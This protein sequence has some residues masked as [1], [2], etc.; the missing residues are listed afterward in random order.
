MC[1]RENS[2]PINFI[3]ISLSYHNISNILFSCYSS[4]L[5]FSSY[6]SAYNR[7]TH[8]RIFSSSQLLRSFS[9]NVLVHGV[10]LLWWS[11]HIFSTLQNYY[12]TMGDRDNF[13]DLVLLSR[14]KRK[15]KYLLLGLYL[16]IFYFCLP[17]LLISNV[18]CFDDF[19]S[20]H[21][22]CSCPDSLSCWKCFL[23]FFA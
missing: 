23:L 3:L 16:N 7:P 11:S 5:N 2:W 12:L 19:P 14:D 20:Y 17:F 6:H 4:I 22:F 21:C 15:I 9:M 1:R 18:P 10:P 8:W 13:E